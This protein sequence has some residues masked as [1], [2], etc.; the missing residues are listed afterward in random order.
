M[1]KVNGYFKENKLL[2]ANIIIII[3]GLALALVMVFVFLNSIIKEDMET[4]TRALF[5]GVYTSI[6]DSLENSAHTTR[7][8]CNDYFLQGMLKKEDEIPEEEFENTMAEYLERMRVTNGWEGTYLIS[9]ATNKYYTPDGIGK[10]VDPEN[11][12]YDIW[13]KNFIETGMEYGA[14]LTYDEFNDK[15]YVVFIDYRMDIDNELKA[16]L[17]CA[18]HLSDVTDIMKSYSKKYNID[19]CFTDVYGNTTLDEEEINL[20]EAYYSRDYTADMIRENQIYT[21]EGYIVRKYIPLI[22]MYLVVKNNQHYLS[23]RFLKMLIFFIVYAIIFILILTSYNF[24]KFQ[25][26]RD[27]L[28]KKVRTDYLTKI[29]NVN[30]LQS[31]INLFMDEEGSGLIGGTMFIMDVDHFKEVNDTFGHGKGDEVLM[32]VGR[33]LSKS[34]RGGD[35][36]G[37]LGGDEFMVFSPTLNAYDNVIQK[38]QELNETLKYTLEEDGKSVEISVSI[39]TATYPQDA[40]TYAELYKKADRALYFVKKHGRN[41]Y[42]VYSDL[43]RIKPEQIQNR[44]ELNNEEHKSKIF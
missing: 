36:V 44:G 6:N 10:I 21:S 12:E 9:C 28:K 41:G 29:S 38:A 8:M 37:R 32:K 31:N 1:K 30:G 5:D 23:K 40:E 7:I 42:C 19:I 24:Y 2:L 16:V 39:G 33:E 15:E 25:D 4:N 13:Y 27:V 14:D 34:F 17:G 18:M 35:I 20:G 43:E 3:V 11:D 26:E 22:G